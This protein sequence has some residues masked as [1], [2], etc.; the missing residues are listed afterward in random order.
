MDW[1]KFK[2]EFEQAGEELETRKGRKKSGTKKSKKKVEPEDVDEEPEMK[3]DK[4]KAGTKKSKKKDAEKKKSKK[5][6]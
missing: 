1:E 5:N 6:K 2:K 4:K 3:T